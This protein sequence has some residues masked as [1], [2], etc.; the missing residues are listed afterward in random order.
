MQTEANLHT[1]SQQSASD[2]EVSDL[3]IAISVV[4]KR[5]ARKIKGKTES[6]EGDKKCTESTMDWQDR[7]SK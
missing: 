6:M 2:E 5:L 4:A 3:L 1:A 7:L